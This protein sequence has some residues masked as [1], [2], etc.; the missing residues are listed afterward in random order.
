MRT[1]GWY[2][3]CELYLYILQLWSIVDSFVSFLVWLGFNGPVKSHETMKGN[4]K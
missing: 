2:I 4:L 3:Y 1:F